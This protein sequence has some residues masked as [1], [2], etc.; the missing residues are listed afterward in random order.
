MTLSNIVTSR[1]TPWVFFGVA[2]PLRFL[3]ATEPFFEHPGSW[4]AAI[5]HD[6]SGPYPPP[7]YRGRLGI[8]GLGAIIVLL[9]HT[10]AVRNL[11]REV[12][13]TA[14]I[15]VAVHPTLVTMSTDYVLLMLP[16]FIAVAWRSEAGEFPRKF[17]VVFL[18]MW[19]A[20]LRT[21]PLMVADW[22]EEASTVPSIWA[23]WALA[24]PEASLRTTLSAYL[25][26]GT[27]LVLALI[28]AWYGLR[29]NW[30]LWVPLLAVVL[31]AWWCSTLG[32]AFL[33]HSIR[34]S[35]YPVFLLL[36]ALGLHRIHS[37]LGRS[38]GHGILAVDPVRA[39]RP[40]E[41]AADA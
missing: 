7:S 19:L 33:S 25:V 21:V 6:I 12:A 3:F 10:W 2:V 8:S 26:D 27:T 15:L 24:L 37:G 29:E 39:P 31:Y 9:I 13:G 16:L 14:V 38:G 35:V 11:R 32:P 41:K 22:V 1:Y 4:I 23:F 17:S 34:V 5:P 36:A 40:P 20:L 30:R 28:G 18:L